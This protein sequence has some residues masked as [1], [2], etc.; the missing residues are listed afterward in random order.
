MEDN[1]FFSN[2]FSY[3]KIKPNSSI[4]GYNICLARKEKFD[5]FINISKKKKWKKEKI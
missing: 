4:F 1:N 5:A 3:F 2:F